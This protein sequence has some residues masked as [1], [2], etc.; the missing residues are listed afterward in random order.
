MP[1]GTPQ[2]Q[3]KKKASFR[4]RLKAWQKPPQPL[5]IVTEEPKPRFVYTPTHAA[6]DFSRLAVS[7][8]SRSGH[9]F[10]PDRRRPSQGG[11]CG[12]EEEE[13]EEEQSPRRHSRPGTNH[14][15]DTPTEYSYPSANTAARVPVNTQP[16]VLVPKEAQAQG[17]QDPAP[18]SE[19]LSDYELFIAR[20]EAED[21]KW[22]EKIL[23][24]ITQR[25][26]AGPSTNR[27]RPNPHQQFATAVVSSS[28]GRSVE[29][30]SDESVPP[31]KNSSRS[32]HHATSSA[33]G[34]EQ[35][36]QR[37]DQDQRRPGPAQG[38][39]SSGTPVAENATSNKRLSSSR[40]QLAPVQQSW[41]PGSPQLTAPHG[42]TGG[43]VPAP[44]HKAPPPRT[45][46]RQA[47]LTQRIARYIKP[48]KTVDNRRVEPL[49][50]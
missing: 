39:T 38:S 8:L 28:A 37:Q 32:H 42:A 24:S 3:L 36:L 6:A 47:S 20:A 23:Q 4:D 7:P 16:P 30:G 10:P 26:T 11:V 49:V 48:A 45:L 34:P 18:R 40:P 15:P 43:F 13:E 33:N 9:R 29:K 21:R 1:S 12:K 50:E 22:R 17:D 19:P 2:S 31:R 35:R 25:A 27:V 46:R 44:E 14:H 41:P 5:E